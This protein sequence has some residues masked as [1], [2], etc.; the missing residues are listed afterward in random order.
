MPDFTCNIPLTGVISAK[1]YGKA[2]AI[3]NFSDSYIACFDRFLRT[4]QAMKPM[5]AEPLKATG[6]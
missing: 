6:L 2:L 1:D 5:T 4:Q 3:H